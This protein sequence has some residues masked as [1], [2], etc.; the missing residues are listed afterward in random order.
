M[1]DNVFEQHPAISAACVRPTAYEEIAGTAVRRLLAPVDARLQ[2]TTRP[3]G[4]M[5]SDGTGL[6]G[7]GSRESGVVQIQLEKAAV[8]GRNRF[9]AVPGEQPRGKPV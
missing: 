6:P 1:T 2:G 8:V 7:A 3:T 5:A 4:A 9:D